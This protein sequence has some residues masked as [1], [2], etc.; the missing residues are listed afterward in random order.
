[1]KTARV[2]LTLAALA[3]GASQAAAA[4]Y[5]ER[6]VVA[7][8]DDS[9]WFG[10]FSGGRN[11]AP[12]AEPIPLDWLDVKQNFVSLRD[13]SAWVKELTRAYSTYEGWK[14]CVRLR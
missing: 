14:T 3:L 11:L 13:C 5:R 12:G 2:Y 9:L 7:P 8:V 1:M 6:I 10:H 4:D